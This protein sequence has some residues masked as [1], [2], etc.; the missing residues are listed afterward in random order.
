MLISEIS[1]EFSICA[2]NISEEQ[3]G[4]LSSLTKNRGQKQS[5]LH[6]H[7]KQS[8]KLARSCFS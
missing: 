4:N 7:S 1:E 8:R 6:L 5:S 3:V 2:E